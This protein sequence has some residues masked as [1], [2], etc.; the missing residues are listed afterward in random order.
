[1]PIASSNLH[2]NAYALA[3]PIHDTTSQKKKKR[4]VPF[5]INLNPN[6]QSLLNEGR[7]S[8]KQQGRIHNDNSSCCS[9]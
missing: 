5:V 2:K 7:S 3:I 6:D 4:P 1:V 9:T 8:G